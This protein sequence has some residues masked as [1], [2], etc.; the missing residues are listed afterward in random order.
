LATRSTELC[1]E[2]PVLS[3]LAEGIKFAVL[4]AS[5]DP[6]DPMARVGMGK[7]WFCSAR[8]VESRLFESGFA[9]KKADRQ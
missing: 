6:C 3:V 2:L 7:C 9:I 5:T 8:E 1:L 4:S